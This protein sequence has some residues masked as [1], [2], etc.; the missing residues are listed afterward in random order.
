MAPVVP[1]APALMLLDEPTNHLDVHQQITLL[2]R[3]RALADGGRGV[4][5]SL[6]DV[7]LAARF[8]DHV[9]LLFGK[10]EWQGGI[11]SSLLTP[12]L[13]TRLYGHPI[14]A[15]HGTDGRTAFVAH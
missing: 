9:L 12:E 11:T 2:Q 8:C 15:L 10:G 13:L 3:L 4:L 5:M 7:N 14:E 1:V 6:H